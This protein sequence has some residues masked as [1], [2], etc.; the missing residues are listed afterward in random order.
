MEKI[1][2]IMPVYN[3][4]L[5]KKMGDF[6]QN[7][8]RRYDKNNVNELMEKIYLETMGWYKWLKHLTLLIV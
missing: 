5:R 4:E 8:A 7:L 2:V 3:K 6:N 1:S